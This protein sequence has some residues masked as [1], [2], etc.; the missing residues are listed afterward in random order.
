MPLLLSE[1]FNDVL[2]VM[3][4]NIDGHRKVPH[5]L[6]AIKG[7]GP[8]YANIVCKRAEI[9]SDKRAGELSEEEVAK[10]IT[11]M[12]NPIEH[13]IPAHFLNRQKDVKTGTSSQVLSNNV[14][15]KVREDIEGLKKSHN[16]RGLRHHWG[17]TVRG[18]HTKTTGRKGHTVG[19]SK[20]K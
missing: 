9:D 8:S 12:S 20:K 4:T 17:L 14:D 16:H 13:G 5:A 11:V 2:R 7:V 15:N 3:N 1:N 19:V 18:Q 10:L 6:T